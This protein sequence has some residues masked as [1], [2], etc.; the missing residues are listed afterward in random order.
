MTLSGKL[1]LDL[2]EQDIKNLITKAVEAETHL[3]V[4]SVTLTLHAGYSDPREHQA[5]KVTASVTFSSLSD[6]PP[7][8]APW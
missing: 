8:R 6:S 3:K 5:P 7:S 1:R 4:S 2:T